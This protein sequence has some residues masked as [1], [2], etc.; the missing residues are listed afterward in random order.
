MQQL[1]RDQLAEQR[2]FMLATF[3]AFARRMGTEIKD[4]IAKVSVPPAVEPVLPP[5]PPVP[6]W[7][8]LLTA[9]FSLVPAAILGFLYWQS[10]QSQAGL[11]RELADTRAEAAAAAAK[12][13]ASVASLPVA[14]ASPAPAGAAPPV[15]GPVA[16]E[17]VP[18]GET[19]LAGARLDR[20]RNVVA[21]TEAQQFKGRIVVESFVGD[22]CLAGNASEGF[23]VAPATL[24]STKCDLV[25][26]PF[27]DA[28]SPAQRQSVDFAN[29]AATLAQRTAGALSVEL[30]NAGRRN[31]VAYPEQGEDST[32]GDWNAIAAQNNRVEFHLVP[33]E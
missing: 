12:A 1:V 18:Y 31:P 28:L 21:A 23:T 9:L 4:G 24:A 2:R 20:L 10:L 11:Q 26:N 13:A 15:A 29:F 3:E 25:G 17:Y 16:T 6:W 30:V 27:D 5:P 32:A 33:A 14:A 7:P 19:P 8:A 22:F